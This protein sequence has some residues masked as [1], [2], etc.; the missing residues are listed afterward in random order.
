MLRDM[1]SRKNDLVKKQGR[2]KLLLS[3][4]TC[5]PDSSATTLLSIGKE[6]GFCLEAVHGFLEEEG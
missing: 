2:L 6:S 3:K 5:W 1:K 4:P